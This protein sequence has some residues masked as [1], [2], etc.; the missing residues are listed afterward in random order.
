M[1]T[2]SSSCGNSPPLALI[3]LRRLIAIGLMSLALAACG[4]D[5]AMA[6]DPGPGT[7]P[8]GAPGGSTPDPNDEPPG[9]PAGDAP[10]L[11]CI[12][13]DYPCSFDAVSLQVIEHSL[14]LSDEVA[15]QLEEGADIEDVAAFLAAQSDIADVTVDGPVL[16][17]RLAGGRPMIVDVTGDQEFLPSESATSASGAQ[18]AAAQLMT[19][20]VGAKN[21]R[22]VRSAATQAITGGNKSQRHALV[23]SPFRFEENFGNS[24]VLVAEA[25]NG[26]RG[27]AGNVTYLATTNEFEPQVTVDLLTQLEQYEVIHIDTHGGTICKDKDGPASA[28]LIAD[29]DKDKEKKTCENGVTDFLVQR[30]H[31]TAQDLQSIAHPG[32]IHYRGRLHQSIAVTADF[33]RHYYPDGLSDTLFVLGSCNT[34]RT[35][36]AEAIAGSRGVFMSWDGSTEESLVRR[37][38]LAMLD[39]L[40]AGLT[41]GEAHVRLPDFT[42]DESRCGGLDPAA[43]L[44]QGGRRPAH[45]RPAH[46]AGQSHRQAG[47]RYQRHRGHGRSR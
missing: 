15:R 37:T 42:P 12:Q 10:M 47:Q 32:V 7:P 2:V 11:D 20:T 28:G 1:N 36:M 13:E 17:F 4:G 41:V 38:S 34:F 35:D 46:R 39:Y 33:F 16:G 18:E 30:F 6:P 40:G 24:G 5:G 44:A 31:G 21:L 22:T 27:Y 25:L 8:P 23:L 45:P 26:I 14:A 43:F 29:K 19:Q 3:G 9:D